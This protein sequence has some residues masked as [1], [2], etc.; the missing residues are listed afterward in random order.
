M[1]RFLTPSQTNEILQNHQTPLYVY[2]EQELRDRAK[3]MMSFPHA[4]GL[5]VKFAMKANTNQHI[6]K[7][8]EEEGIQFDAWSHFELHRA[9]AVGIPAETIQMVG[10][11]LPKD[12]DSVLDTWAFIVASS[13]HQLEQYAAAMKRRWDTWWIWI[14]INPGIWSWDFAQISTWGPTS[15]F[16]IRYEY[17]DQARSIASKNGIKITK[18]HCHIWSENTAESWAKSAELM[19]WFVKD[20][21][22]ARYLNLWWG[23]KM[24][25]MPYERTADLQAIWSAVKEKI[26]VFYEHTG[27]KLH[28]EIEPG[29]YLVIN[30]CSVLSTIQD[31]CDTWPE[32]H[33]FLKL[34]SGMTE[35]PRVP[36]YG[37]QEPL[38]IH[39]VTSQPTER[40]KEYVVVWHCCESWDLI[41]CKLYEP[42][43]IEPRALPECNIWDVMIIDWVWAYSSSM[44]M[45]HY[46][47][48][49][50]AAELLL[51]NEWK[52]K[53]IRKRQLLSDMWKN[54]KE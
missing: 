10:Q 40:K 27:R 46:N 23:F 8:F 47:S 20:F 39:H 30:S 5:T 54:E 24:A 6:L 21:P 32:G 3:E 13:L 43:I 1:T 34:D 14:R 31:I 7:I 18:I 35:M 19:L 29:K 45:K 17:L 22:D 12:I 42:E 49:P 50:E 51:T 53:T 44:A 11:E 4:Y 2:S 33:T 26:E 38:H 37:I 25:I 16:W 52:I 15:S 41:T 48:F 28:L 9:I 36:M